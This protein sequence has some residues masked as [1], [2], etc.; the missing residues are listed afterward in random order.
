MAFLLGRDQ[1]GDE[2][3]LRGVRIRGDD[4]VSEMTDHQLQI[5]PGCAFGQLQGLF[6][7]GLT[8]DG[9]RLRLLPDAALWLGWVLRL[10]VALVLLGL[11]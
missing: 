10:R 7:V 5:G 9:L 3:V 4:H 1:L 8:F 11:L 2:R 6:V